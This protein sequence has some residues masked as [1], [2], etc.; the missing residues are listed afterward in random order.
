MHGTEASV[1]EQPKKA[2][3]LGPMPLRALAVVWCI[4]WA[5]LIGAS[6]QDQLRHGQLLLICRP[7][8]N[9]GSSFVVSSGLV[10]WHWFRVGRLDHIL[11]TPW[12]WF[13]RHLMWLPVVALGFVVANYGLR[14]VAFELLGMRYSLAPWGPLLAYE[15]TKFA[16]FYVLYIGVVF[17]FRSYGQ[18]LGQTFEAERS[19]NAAKQA[20]LLQLAQQIEPHFLFNALGTI[21]ETIHKDPHQADRLLLKLSSLLRAATD[22]GRVTE[23]PLGEELQLI[24]GYGEIMVERFGERVQ[25]TIDVDPE[26]RLCRVPVFLLQPLVEN[27]FKHGVEKQ[28]EA[29]T[30]LVS[31]FKS[32][33]SSMRLRVECSAGVVDK[34]ICKGVGLSNLVD[35]LAARYGDRATLSLLPRLGGGTV[36]SVEMPCEY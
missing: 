27:A 36:A 19:A 33:A 18:M 22:L 35:R 24:E 14:A 34:T 9:E 31:G 20:Q 7:L 30:V 29:A 32:G 10:L 11:S 8:I 3:A 23:A 15:C 26:L 1:A 2:V 4:L 16:V 13:F 6:L 12:R 28:L 21:A 5:L 25:F 17:G